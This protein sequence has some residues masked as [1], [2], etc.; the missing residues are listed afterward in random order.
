MFD[1]LRI[2]G[3]LK[4]AY[5]F[6][7]GCIFVFNLELFDS[8]AKLAR[9]VPVFY[10]YNTR[11]T[12]DSALPEDNPRYDH[13]REKSVRVPP[14]AR[15]V[16]NTLKSMSGGCLPGGWSSPHPRFSPTALA[17]REGTKYTYRIIRRHINDGELSRT[18]RLKILRT[19]VQVIPKDVALTRGSFPAL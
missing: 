2:I 14:M 17:R 15:V 5:T 19:N 18:G 4:I 11:N 10:Q 8:P 3:L 12:F 16:P 6:V 13:T 7:Y 9:N 1:K